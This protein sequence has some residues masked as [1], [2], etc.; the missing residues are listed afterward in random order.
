MN[1]N[2]MMGS[3]KGLLDGATG[4]NDNTDSNATDSNGLSGLMDMAK[5]INMEELERYKNMSKAELMEEL[6]NSEHKETVVNFIK[7]LIAKK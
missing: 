5:D 3:A 7:G 2:D 1:M 4:D 6:K